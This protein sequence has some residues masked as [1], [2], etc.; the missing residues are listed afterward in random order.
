MDML[1]NQMLSGDKGLPFGILTSKQQST[2][3]EYILSPA[4]R[5]GLAGF[6]RHRKRL[7]FGVIILTS[8][9]I[10]LF[11][12]PSTALL[13]IPTQQSNW[14]AGGASFWLAGDDEDH[15]PSKLTALSTG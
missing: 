5:F 9:L 1:R 2:D 7:L 11:T 3:L 15:W 13:V 10:S 14:P 8:T 12:G 4:F 6:A